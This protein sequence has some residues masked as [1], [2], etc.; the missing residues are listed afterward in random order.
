MSAHG[1]ARGVIFFFKT[2]QRSPSTLFFLVFYLSSFTLALDVTTAAQHASRKT[3]PYFVPRFSADVH[4]FF[5]F[6]LFSKHTERSPLVRCITASA[7][8][9]SIVVR[10]TSAARTS[11][12]GGRN[13]D[14]IINR[15]DYHRNNRY[16]FKNI[17][18]STTIYG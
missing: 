3:I 16:L 10:A 11:P 13:N 5:F 8:S 4:F 15:F 2:R 1:T 14:V 9:S 17:R 7:V 12:R 6:S 18:L